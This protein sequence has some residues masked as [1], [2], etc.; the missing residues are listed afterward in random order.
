MVVVTRAGRPATAAIVA[1]GSELLNLGRTDTNSPYIAAVLQRHG[2][3]VSST[4][5]VGDDWDDLVATLRHAHARAD[6]V[7]CTGGLGPTDDDRTRDAAAHVLGLAL[8]EAPEVVVAIRERFRA[9]MTDR[10]KTFQ[11]SLQVSDPY[12]SPI[13]A[14]TWG[15][16]KAKAMQAR[17]FQLLALHSTAIAT[18]RSGYRST[19][20]R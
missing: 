14:Y 7:V 3:A 12:R 20:E 5:V 6:L 17:L 2:L 8:H 11:A 18:P 10:S 15:S 9:G 1:V 13:Q 19:C 16:N 4:T